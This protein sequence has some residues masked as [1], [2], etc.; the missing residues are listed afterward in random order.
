M[1]NTFIGSKILATGQSTPFTGDWVNIA[2]ARNAMLVVFGSGV[3]ATVPVKIQSRSELIG[4]N[5]IFSSGGGQ[6]GVDFYTFSSVSNGYATPAFLDSP[7]SQI[8]L[9]APS[10]TAQIF[11][12]VSIQN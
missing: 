5:S 8:R 12:Y 11:G 7:M 4:L 6:D 10:G 1:N 3:T 2:D 9:V